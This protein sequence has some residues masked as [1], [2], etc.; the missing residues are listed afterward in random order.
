VGDVVRT[1]AGELLAV[2]AIEDGGQW[3]RVYNWEIEDYHTYFVSA[4]EDG[5]SI[6]AHNAD[7]CH[8]NSLS[9]TRETT[10]YELVDRATGG[11]LKWGISNNPARRYSQTFLNNN[12]ARLVPIMSGTRRRM[13]QIERSLVMQLPGPWNITSAC[14]I[15][16][17]SYW[18]HTGRMDVGSNS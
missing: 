15:F 3:E 11:I 10:L 17:Y 13:A 2:E 12:N 8:G 9:N 6:W 4:S 14:K 18:Q 7:G 5:A 1:D 16:T